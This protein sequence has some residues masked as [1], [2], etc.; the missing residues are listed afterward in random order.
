M[1]HL[2]GIDIGEVIGSGPR[3]VRQRYILAKAVLEHLYFGANVYKSQPRKFPT[4]DISEL[5][6]P[7]EGQESQKCSYCMETPDGASRSTPIHS[8]AGH[9]IYLCY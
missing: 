1:S 9:S 5:P 7:D 3:K 4:C 8:N 2:S 6:E